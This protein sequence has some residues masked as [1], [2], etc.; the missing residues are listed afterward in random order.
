MANMSYVRFENTLGDLLDCEE[1]LRNDDLVD[2]SESEKKHAKALIESCQRIAE[3]FEDY[4][5]LDQLF[6]DE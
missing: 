6:E 2:L 4:G 3:M 1:H 5:E